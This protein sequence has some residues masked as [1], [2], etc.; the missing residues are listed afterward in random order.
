MAYMA[1]LRAA[2][3]DRVGVVFNRLEDARHWIEIEVPDEVVEIVAV[4]RKPAAL[5]AVQG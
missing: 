3:G 1:L 5:R 4:L 2:S